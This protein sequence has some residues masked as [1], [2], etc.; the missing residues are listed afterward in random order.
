MLLE[1]CFLAEDHRDGAD[2]GWVVLDIVGGTTCTM[3][4]IVEMKMVKVEGEE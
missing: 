4:A 1:Y 3:V 2:G